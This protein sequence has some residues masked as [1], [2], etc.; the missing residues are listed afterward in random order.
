MTAQVEATTRPYKIQGGSLVVL[1]VKLLK[2]LKSAKLLLAGASFALEA[3]FVV[4][5]RLWIAISPPPCRL[6][7]CRRR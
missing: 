6:F 1:F 3:S 4:A 2:V 5:T 7:P